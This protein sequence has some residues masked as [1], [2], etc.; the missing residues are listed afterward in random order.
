[1]H[2]CEVPA[3]MGKFHA[4]ED[5]RLHFPS[6]HPARFPELR[7]C[8]GSWEEIQLGFERVDGLT[9]QV[10][11]R[12]PATAAARRSEAHERAPTAAAVA[13]GD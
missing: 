6:L 10:Q 4:W 5:A 8:G 3:F 7:G 11:R 12:E 9:G 1:M 2:D 13:L